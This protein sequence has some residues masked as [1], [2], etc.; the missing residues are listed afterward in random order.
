MMSDMALKAKIG[1]LGLSAFMIV[2]AVTFA[3]Y[4]ALEQELILLLIAF[5]IFVTIGLYK[6]IYYLI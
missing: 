5:M 3:L 6:S 4:M 1:V 2:L